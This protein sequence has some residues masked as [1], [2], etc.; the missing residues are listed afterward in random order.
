MKWRIAGWAFVAVVAFVAAMTG[1]DLSRIA[2][3][4]VMWTTA[5]FGFA[6]LD[7]AYST[8]SSIMPQKKNPDIAE[9]VRGKT[10][11]LVGNLTALLVTLKGLPLSYNRDLQ[12]DKEPLFDAVDTVT[13]ALAALAGLLRTAELRT[14]RMQAAA[15]PRIEDGACG[16]HRHHDQQRLHEEQH[17]HIAVERQ[18][19]R[20]PRQLD[21]GR[22]ADIAPV[23]D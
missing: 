9:L 10:G 12:E 16:R 14:E 11:R 17:L 20:R 8:G 18:R 13:L 21:T 6:R 19:D 23:G 3:E 7:D 5:E 15:D 2:E 4:V 1:V 22:S